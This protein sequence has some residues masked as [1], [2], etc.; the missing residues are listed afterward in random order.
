MLDFIFT[1]LYQYYEKREKGGNSVFSSSIYVSALRFLFIFSGVMMLDIFSGNKLSFSSLHFDKTLGK[2]LIILIF[3][4]M[5]YL[6]YKRYK[7]K[8][9]ELLDKYK[10]SPCN[11]W[12]KIWMVGALIM[13][14]FL[15]PI[16]WN[17]MY[18]LFC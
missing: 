15:S 4:I 6:D 14:L 7:N 18:K 12:F 16:L 17:E 9:K 10:N 13:I 2:V 5:M 11:D 3:A 1:R 8:Y